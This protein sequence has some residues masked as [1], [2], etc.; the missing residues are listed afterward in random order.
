M[1]EINKTFELL[2]QVYKRD[3]YKLFRE[4]KRIEKKFDKNDLNR[5]LSQIERSIEFKK[6]RIINKPKVY[7]NEELPVT[8]RKKE[9]IETIKNNQVVIISGQTGSGKTTQIP[10]FCLDA[11]CGESGIIAC[12]QPRRIAA[13]SVATRLAEE[14]KTPLGQDVGYKIRFGEEFSDKGYIKVLTDGMLLAETQGDRFLNNYDCIIIDEAHERSLNIDFILGILRDLLK[15]RKDLKVVITSATIDTEKFSKAFNNA[16]VIE[17]SGR[18]FPVEVIY[19]EPEAEDLESSFGERAASA[20][21][22][23]IETTPSGDVL[24]FLPTEQDIRECIE[25]LNK[26][27]LG[28]MELLPLY[29]RLTQSEQKA[30]FTRTN[31]RKI[32][33][34]TNIAETSL[35]IPGIKYVIDSGVA[36]ISQYSHQTRT[37]GLPVSPISKSS[38]DQRKGRCGRVE[39]GICIRLYSE[40]DYN[41]RSLFTPPEIQRTNL[42]EV[43]LRMISLKLSDVK[44]FPFIDTPPA[45]G[46]KDG[47]DLLLELGA[48]KKHRDS[49]VLTSDGKI[50]SKY[51]IDPRDSRM[52]LE[53]KKE[54]CVKEISAIAAV[55]SIHDPRNRPKEQA[56]QADEK[57]NRFKHPESDFLTLL[58]IWNEYQIELNKRASTNGKIKNWCKTNFISYKR[59]REWRDIYNQ[60]ITLNKENNITITSLPQEDWTKKELN[61]NYGRI[62]RSILTGYLSTI[63]LKRE[64]N[65]Y[66]L[67]RDREGMIYPGSGLF[68]NGGEWVCSFEQV[69]T[70]RLFLRTVG[71]IDVEWLERLGG[72]LCKRSYSAP[73]YSTELGQVRALE[74]V[75]LFGL[76]I[77]YNRDVDYGLYNK[78]EAT[79]IFIQTCLV[80]GE[81]TPKQRKEYKFLDFNLSLIEKISKMED[82]LRLRNILVDSSAIDTFYTQKITNISSL[83]ELTSLI[84]KKSGDDFLRMK[85]EDLYTSIPGGLNE[86]PDTYTLGD[87][88]FKIDYNFD[89]G[90]ELDGVTIKV[91]ARVAMDVPKEKL[92]TAIP[93]LLKDRIT[94]LIKGLPKVY[95]KRLI[96]IN[97]TVDDIIENMEVTDSN[98]HL[99][100][101]NYIYRNWRFNIPVGEWDDNKLPEYLKIRVAI[102]DE[103]GKEIKSSRDGDILYDDYSKRLNNIKKVKQ[104]KEEYE[105]TN[106][107]TWDFKEPIEKSVIIKGIKYY[108]GLKVNSDTVS[109][110][111]FNREKEALK[112]HIEGTSL[113]IINRL[114]KQ[115]KAIKEDI[116]LTKDQSMITNY[117]DG[118]KEFY[119]QLFFRLIKDCVDKNI[120]SRSDFELFVESLSPRLLELSKE[121]ISR[122]IPILYE[123]KNVRESLSRVIDKLGNRGESFVEDINNE[124]IRLMPNDFLIKAENYNSLLRYLKALNERINKG[125]LNL[126]K[127]REKRDI[128]LYYEQKYAKILED[129]SPAASMEK[130]ELMREY[131]VLLEEFRVSVFA[132]NIKIPVKVSEKRL[133]TILEQINLTI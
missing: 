20:T 131:T 63:A 47:Y 91:P 83:N 120:R 126:I 11:G 122:V 68:N 45:K 4:L 13:I 19:R 42:G 76:P 96:P 95:R 125:P 7:Y 32:I 67:T 10:K 24:V 33:V 121:H 110:L 56:S 40:A 93:G 50:M 66:R 44:S 82:K 55:V 117:F 1:T 30:V 90:K 62:H 54:G 65:F 115:L 36:R 118:E 39:N 72:E 15:K 87:S 99:Q 60:I 112:E 29:A 75:T 106:I 23:L 97:S 38:A 21:T 123:Y 130:L 81:L 6:S 111:L 25:N 92:D 127:D 107:T 79:K 27:F 5:V 48:I 88:T 61:N 46:I 57:H 35:T 116:L 109:L 37:M 86:F 17:V 26:N 71:N 129:L 70:S 100:L 9:I 101:S 114:N 133:L 132:G 69:K 22:E 8:K 28:K 89:P 41:K 85:E 43:I 128:I 103:K 49:W 78:N 84:R 73:Y 113:L 64:K 124:L 12:T 119:K 59:L 31:K 53:A 104:A 74:R 58:N 16:P 51:P 98:L 3:W 108:P 2:K 102:I 94:A 14:L 18:T 34:S 77:V 105:R 52:I 80:E